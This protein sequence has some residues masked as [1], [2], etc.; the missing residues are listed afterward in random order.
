MLYI[1][2][3]IMLLIRNACGRST[4]VPY[5]VQRPAPNVL[6]SAR[7]ALTLLPEADPVAG[8]LELSSGST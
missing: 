2:A 1:I 3:T 8:T 5:A 7:E 4:C 6:D